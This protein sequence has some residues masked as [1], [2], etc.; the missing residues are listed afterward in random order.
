MKKATIQRTLHYLK[1]IVEDKKLESS[2]DELLSFAEAIEE[3]SSSK[4]DG[5]F[6]VPTIVADHENGFALF[7]DGA[8][9]GNPGPGAW[10]MVGQQSNGDIVFQ[11]SGVD[12]RTTNNRM[13]LLGAIEALKSLVEHLNDSLQGGAATVTSLTKS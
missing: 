6:V 12:T 10:G 7:S 4:S 13:E 2:I 11:A 5:S 9:R 1:K 3:T 8:C